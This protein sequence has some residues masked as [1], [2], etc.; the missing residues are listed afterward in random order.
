[1]KTVGVIAEFNPFHNGHAYLI[2]KAREI[3]GADH[4]VII[5]SGN[6]V[7]RGAPAFMDKFT[8]TAIALENNADLVLELPLCYSMA[9][10][11]YFATGAV[12]TLDKL[13]VI[14]Y[15]CFG[16]ENDDIH[17]LNLISDIIIQEDECYSE[18]LQSYLKTGMS[19]SKSRENAIIKSLSLRGVN[20][21]SEE[22]SLIISSPNSILAIEYII[23]IKKSG[24]KM[25]PIPIKRSDNGYHSLDFD[26]HFASAS[27]I[28]KLFTGKSIFTFNN[29][30]ETLYDIVPANCMELL[31]NE[32]KKT[33]PVLPEDFSSLIG[34]ALITAKY[35]YTDLNNLFDITDDLANRISNLTGSYTDFDSF[36]NTC[37]STIFTSS[38]ISR[39]L[40]YLLFKY[41]KED[42]FTFK[43]DG[44]VY[45][46][47][48]LGFNK[49]HNDLLT[50]MKT[51]SDIPLITKLS[52]S[53]PL[54]SEN[55]KRMISL[56]MMADE[57]YRM[58]IMNKFK[59]TIPT[60]QQYGVIIK[61]D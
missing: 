23:A 17:L 38:R 5:M 46:F 43:E 28:R 1:M 24:S 27:A 40:F 61:D 53:V 10:A 58:V 11:A 35:D 8:R 36:V 34:N 37:N 31:E 9:S 48:V 7:Q 20:I 42:Y 13:N 4:V 54:L 26:G 45:Y 16:S 39:I 21:S 56:N 32:Y 2:D 50:E 33:Y 47:R 3:T 60:E 57:I 22:L 12:N 41:T 6:F 25:I 59:T 55:G 44:Y 18:A 49:S 29:I 52:N 51:C 19:F 15:L 14:D 30:R